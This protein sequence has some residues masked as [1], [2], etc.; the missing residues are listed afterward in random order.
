MIDTIEFIRSKKKFSKNGNFLMLGKRSVKNE[1]GRNN[2]KKDRKE[3]NIHV[4]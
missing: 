3:R 4:K 2:H 1:S